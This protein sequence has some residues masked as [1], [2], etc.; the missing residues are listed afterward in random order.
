MTERERLRKTIRDLHG[1]E[2]SH[3]RSARVQEVFEGQ[4]VW[5]G[6]VEVFALKGH[7]K[8]GLAYA[9]SCETDDGGRRYVAVLGVHPIKTAQDAVRVSIAAEHGRR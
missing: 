6:V 2:S 7:P 3:L 4:T 9:W 8:A 1:V 5:E